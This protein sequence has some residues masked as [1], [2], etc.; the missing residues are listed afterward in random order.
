MEQFNSFVSSRGLLK[1]CSIRNAKPLSSVALIDFSRHNALTEGSTT[2]YVCQDA[3]GLFAEHILGSI[4]KPFVLLSGDSDLPVTED[5]PGFT[6]VVAHPHLKAWFGQNMVARGDKLLPLPIGLDYHTAWEMVGYLEASTISPMRQES[7]L[8]ATIAASKDWANRVPRAYCNWQFT[9][10]GE[11][12]ECLERV[13]REACYFEPQRIARQQSWR[14]QSA[15]MFTL[16]PAGL[17]MDCHRT[18]EGLLLGAIPI[19]R[20]NAIAPVYAG[21]PVLMV[22]DWAEVTPAFLHYWA[23]RLGEQTFDFNP[24]LLRYWQ[25]RIQFRT[26]DDSFANLTIDAFRG[27]IV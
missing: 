10:Y 5:L 2:I 27:L 1:S 24:L 7:W 22:E 25:D 14:N 26:P 20:R 23:G 18:W 6:Q 9:P 21:L 3:L 17:G 11:R 16:S 8:K 19:V 4:D 12:V 15:F 13:D